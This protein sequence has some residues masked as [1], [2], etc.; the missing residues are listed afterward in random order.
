MPTAPLIIL[1]AGGTGGHLF[2]AEALGEVLIAR[3]CRVAVFTDARGLPIAERMPAASVHEV[4]SASPSTAALWRRMVAYGRLG[5]GL[6][7][8][9]WLMLRHR[10]AVVVGFGGYPSVPTLVAAAIAGVPIVLHE[11]NAVLGRANALMLRRA[12]VIATSFPDTAGIGQAATVLVGNPVRAAIRAIGDYIPPVADEPL[13][14]VITGGSQG[15]RVFADVVPDALATLPTEMRHRLH[16]THQVRSEDLE[17]VTQ[18]YRSAGVTADTAPFFHDLPDRLA[19][20]HLAIGRAGASSVMEFAVAGIPAILVPL[21]GALDDHQSVNARHA[22]AAG[23]AE[24]IAQDQFTGPALAR[25][26]F[27]LLRDADALHAMSI[28]QRTWTR[29]DAAA[30]LADLVLAQPTAQKEAA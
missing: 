4:L 1:A 3:G 17:R 14:L 20:C 16:I 24:A 15:A 7:Q 8:A 28:A 23:G 30:A 21:P 19:R 25:R 9:R 10:P 27:A 13:R 22:A 2:P 18:A 5:V 26:L 12:V 29:R 6:M 11:Q